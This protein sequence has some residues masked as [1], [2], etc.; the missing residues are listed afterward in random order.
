[1]VSLHGSDVFLAERLLPARILARRALHRAGGVTACSE[2]LRR[3]GVALG[4]APER[5]RVVPYGVDPASGPTRPAAEVRRRLGVPDG[6]LLVLG[7]GRLV[8]KKGFRHLVEAAGRVPG[9]HVVIAGEGDLREDLVR[10]VR[11]ANAPVH[12][13]GALDRAAVADAF[14]AADLVV[15]PSVVDAA[16][17]VDGLPNVL[18]EGLAAGRAVVATRVAAIPDVVEDGVTGVLVAP[19]DP[20]QLAQALS[21]LAADPQRREQLGRRARAVM[22]ER[23]GWPAAG[24]AFEETYAQAAALDAR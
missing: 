13:V 23:Y 21:D 4:A 3:R 20:A 1:V 6:R 16:G 17:N 14:A 11:E 18:L 2:D 9:V 7:L 10:R 8:E 22:E 5:T 24:R 15:V 12:F 19:G